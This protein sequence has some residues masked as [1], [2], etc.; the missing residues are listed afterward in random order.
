MTIN[1]THYDGLRH[2]VTCASGPEYIA[3]WQAYRDDGFYCQTPRLIDGKAHFDVC[4]PMPGE[5][6]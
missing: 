5:A 3:T 4:K 2:T 1:P 6:W